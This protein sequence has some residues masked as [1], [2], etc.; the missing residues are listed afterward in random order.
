MAIRKK[1]LTI[2]EAKLK[3]A[4]L[5]ARSE[6][7]S[8]SIEKKLY[9]LGLSSSQRKEIITFL[10]EERYLDDYRYARSFANDKARFN[11]WGPRK[12]RAALSVQKISGIAI[13]EALEKIDEKIWEEGLMKCARAKAKY[14]D[15]TGSEGMENCRKLFVYLMGRGFLSSE[16][17]KAV[18]LMKK[19]QKEEE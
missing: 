16:S 7:C 18:K 2:E 14:L 11:H 12:I 6:Q 15:L 13:N 19:I 3:M 17:S 1:P 10:E 4:G 9:N 5:C 8:F